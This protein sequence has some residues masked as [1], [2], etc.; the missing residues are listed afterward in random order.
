METYTHKVHYYETDKMGVTHHSNY[1][2][3]MEEARVDFLEQIG[4]GYRKLEEE[5]IISPVIGVE[6]D[7]KTP[8]T[9]DDDVEI[10]V[11]VKEFR[12]VR[13]TIGYVMKRKS[14]GA[15][16]LTGRTRHCFVDPNGRPIILERNFPDVAR[17]LAEL[18]AETTE[19][20]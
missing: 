19:K 5:G 1:I 10:E 7:F 9:F 18:Y 6:C 13:L 2:R 14:D 4:Y 8:T 15:L 16:V 12:G 11:S 20:E 3:W 17:K